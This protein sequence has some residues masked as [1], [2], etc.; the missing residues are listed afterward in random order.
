[1]D[2]IKV[3]G[4]RVM[5]CHGVLPQEKTNPQPFV[6]NLTLECDLTEASITDR[7]ECTVHYGEL[8]ELAVEYVQTHCFDL[9]ERLAGGLC[10]LILDRYDRVSA[11]TVEVEKPRAPIPLDFAQVSVVLRRERSAT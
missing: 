4:L 3:T 9:I 8:S 10:Q 2:Q 5:A 1:M 6:L 11:V 7:L